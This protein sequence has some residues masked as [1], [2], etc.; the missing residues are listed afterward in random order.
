MG[1][2]CSIADWDSYQGLHS[3]TS[4]NKYKSGSSYKQVKLA[5]DNETPKFQRDGTFVFIDEES[6]IG[7]RQCVTIAPSMYKIVDDGKARAF[8]QGTLP[9]SEDAI[10][11]CPVRC[12]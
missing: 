8:S 4:K 1:D 3:E 11:S 2:A 7:C 5:Y 9:E 12:M 10:R 6:C